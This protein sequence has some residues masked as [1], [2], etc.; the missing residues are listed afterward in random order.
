MCN[1]SVFDFGLPQS[2]L[3]DITKNELDQESPIFKKT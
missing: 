2:L 1:S 3:D